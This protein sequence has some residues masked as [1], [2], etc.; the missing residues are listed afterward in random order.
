MKIKKC[1]NRFHFILL[2]F[3][4]TCLCAKNE[5]TNTVETHQP[6]KTGNFALPSAQQISPLVS[7]G[8]NIVDKGTKQVF[9]EP[10][11]IQ[12][13]M[14][15][16]TTAT[17]SFLYGLSDISSLF[18]SVPAAINYK[19]DGAHSSG[20]SDALIQLEYSF[21][22]TSNRS[23]TTQATFVANATLPSGSIEKSPPTG[24]GSPTFLLGTTYNITTVNWYAFVSPGAILTTKKN[25]F[26]PGAQY[27]YQFGLGRTFL[28]ATNKYIFAGLVEFNGIINE[29]S[30][31]FNQALPDT[32]GKVLGVT[33]SLWFSNKQLILQFGVGFPLY[34]QLNGNQ[35]PNNYIL[36]G[37]AAWLFTPDF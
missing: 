20:L 14:E 37:N 13:P 7:F 16:Y 23:Y 33:P 18:I 24:S 1:F 3:V 31:L 35:Q 2:A 8:Q 17:P 11:Y 28:T 27:L 9:M 29:K 10:D 25:N 12:A 15:H 19:D 32:G 34:Q 21:F 30:S 5:N 36:V 26:K 22:E 6:P 4:S